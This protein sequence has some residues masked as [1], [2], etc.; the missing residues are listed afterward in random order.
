LVDLKKAFEHVDH[1]LLIQAAKGM[2][3]PMH[4]LRASLLSYAGPRRLTFLGYASEPVWPTR[5]IAA[6]S[7]TATFELWLLVAPALRAIKQSHPTA[8]LSLHVDDL[9]AG[10]R[11]HC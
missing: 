7:A 4:V 5:G 11:L 8:V 2:N 6:G 9:S 10:N 3:Y 1:S